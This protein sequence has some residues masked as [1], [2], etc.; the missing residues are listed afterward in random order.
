MGYFWNVYFELLDGFVCV[1][2]IY[3]SGNGE[4]IFMELSIRQK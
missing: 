4:Q 3:S 2:F 1:S